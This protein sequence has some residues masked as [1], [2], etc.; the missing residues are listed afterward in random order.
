MTIGY[1]CAICGQPMQERYEKALCVNEKCTLYMFPIQGQ[2]CEATLKIIT[3]N[4]RLRKRNTTFEKDAHCTWVA[5]RRHTHHSWSD[6][7]YLHKTNCGQVKGL[8]GMEISDKV[9]H[10]CPFCG[11]K[12]VY[13]NEGDGKWRIYAKLY[14]MKE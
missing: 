1:K 3:E 8:S 2:V 6:L 13:V 4:R 12:I 11:R 5:Y 9:F 7:F 14:G 10:Y